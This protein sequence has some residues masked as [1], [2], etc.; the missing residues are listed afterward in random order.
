MTINEALRKVAPIKQVE[1]A[2]ILGITP[3]S[4]GALL[5]RGDAIKL[6]TLLNILDHF[7]ARLS[8]TTED[9]QV[10]DIDSF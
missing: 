7:N 9:G 4:A 5:R 2:E 3:Q 8:I 6:S 1:F 10:L